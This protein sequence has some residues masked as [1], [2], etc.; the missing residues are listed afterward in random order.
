[1]IKRTIK[2]AA[3]TS[4]I[5]E[6]AAMAAVRLAYRDPATG[7]LVVAPRSA[8]ASDLKRLIATELRKSE[9]SRSGKARRTA[10]P[11]KRKRAARAKNR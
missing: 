6:E 1:M 11:V 5:S 3:G 10:K 4:S 8:E 2:P 9:N 7:K